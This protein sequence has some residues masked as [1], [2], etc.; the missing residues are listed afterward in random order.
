VPQST[1]DVDLRYHSGLSLALATAV[2]FAVNGSVIGS[3]ISR[4][5]ATRDRLDADPRAIGLTLLMAG[6]GSLVAMP[7]VGR[8]AHR[9]SSGPVV[10]ATACGTAVALVVASVTPT[11]VTTGAA[12]FALGAA[13]GSWDVA[14]NIQGSY[15]DRTVGRD[16]MPR[17]HASW[18]VGAIVAGAVGAWAA[19]HAVPLV[20]HLGGVALV[21]AA[22]T[23]TIVARWY[24][25]DR[26]SAPEA[27]ASVDDEPLPVARPR[28]LTRRLVL[29]GVITLCGTLLEGSAHDW[30]TLY[31]TDDRQLS[32]STAALG[33]AGFATAMALGRFAGTPVIARLG[34][35]RA[36]RIG[37]V[38]A[39]LGV[40]LT[41]A[42]PGAVGLLV[43][44]LLWG[45]GTSLVF[46]AAMSSGGEQPGRA[47]D[48]I[49]VVSTI[50]YGGFLIGPPLIGLLGQQVG[51]GHALWVL[52]VFGLAIALLAPAV[53]PPARV[54]VTAPTR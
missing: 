16:Y 24:L 34:R 42:L 31:L 21:A 1:D 54:S 50:G 29:I 10:V 30:I 32:P 47:A 13:N 39:T 2:V 27:I 7:F 38:A 51:I 46:P 36:V 52:P 33:F 37:G 3:W 25:D 8:L 28:V 14:M 15:V 23:V 5:P 22:V 44:I 20:V 18:S 19:A 49:A 12:L 43:G 9:Y 26:E 41:L 48:S 40:A 17:Y 4:L 6:I 45:L 11:L 53:A 35:A